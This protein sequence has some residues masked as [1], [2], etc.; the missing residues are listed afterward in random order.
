MKA[1]LLVGH[2][3]RSESVE[4]LQVAK[5]VSGRFAIVETAYL[6]IS[7]PDVGHGIKNCIDRGADSVIVIPYFLHLG[8]HVK[9]DL[10]K[11]IDAQRKTGIRLILGKH[12]GFHEK[13]ADIVI[14]RAEEA[15]A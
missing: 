4:M 2:G 3:S 9:S 12:L 13:L 8:Q 6:S 10:P 7:Q 15:D 14:Q 11:I 1:L 5:R